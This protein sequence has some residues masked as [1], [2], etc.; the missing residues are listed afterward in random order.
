M[1]W[2]IPNFANTGISSFQKVVASFLASA[3]LPFAPILSANRIERVFAKHGGLFGAQGIYSTAMMVWSFLGQ[4]LRN[5]KEASCQ[6]AV[7]RVVS[8]CEHEQM[9]PPT[10]DTGNYCRAREALRSGAA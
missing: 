1:A 7:A 3:A 2:D 5:G 6:A 8:Y 4:V 10:A 9:A